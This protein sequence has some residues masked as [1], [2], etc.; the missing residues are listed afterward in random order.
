MASSSLNAEVGKPYLLAFFFSPNLPLVV[1][2]EVQRV[3][4]GSRSDLTLPKNSHLSNTENWVYTAY[5]TPTHLGWHVVQYRAKTPE[6]E[7]VL[8]N[9]NRFLVEKVGEG[10]TQVIRQVEAGKMVTSVTT[11]LMNQKG[12]LSFKTRTK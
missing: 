6:G 10:Q 2:A 11:N 9:I 3:E 1:T 5:F 12:I 8:S 4:D 7:L